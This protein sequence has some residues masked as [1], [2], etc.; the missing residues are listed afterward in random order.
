MKTEFPSSRAFFWVAN[1]PK[2]PVTNKQI[3]GFLVTSLIFLIGAVIVEGTIHR[4]IFSIAACSHLFI[5]WR[6]FERKGFI[7]FMES[8]GIIWAEKKET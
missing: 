7:E 5:A 3:I 2:K 1:L 8:K 4:F 6:Q